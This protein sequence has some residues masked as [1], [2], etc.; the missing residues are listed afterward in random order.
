[1]IDARAIAIGCMRLS[2]EPDRE[3]ERSI[4]VLR[5]ALE[6]GVTLFD[7][8]DAYGLDEA[9][10]GH[11]ER[12][13]AR[14]LAGWPGDRSQ[15][16]IAT[17][18]GLTRA[19]GRWEPDGRAK[20]LAAACE[21]SCRAL[22]VRA[23]D[24]YQ[25]HAP[26]P[27]TSWSTSIRAL[28][29]LKRSGLVRAIG[30]CNV[31]VRDIEEARRIVDIDA[32]QIELSVWQDAGILGG[33]VGYCLKE[34]IPILAYRPLGGRKSRA[35][36]AAEPVLNDIAARH[37]VSPHEIAIA[38]VRDAAP[39]LI[40]PLPG[41]TRVE[42][43]RSAAHAQRLTLTSHDRQLLDE[44]F[45]AARML[46]AEHGGS[47][48]VS[49][50]RDGEVVMI[51]GIPAAGKTTLAERFERDGF[52]RLNRDNEGGTLR[53][54][55]SRLESAV[56]AGASRI[57][58]DN[59]YGSR[60]S[61][62]EVIRAAADRGLPVRCVWCTTSLEQ[63]QVNA[64]T[65]LI[66]RY[67][68]LPPEAEL[69]RLRKTDVSAFLPTVLFR[70][71]RQLEPPDASE[72]FSRIEQVPFA[73]ARDPAH[74]NRAVIVW[75]DDVAELESYAE[76]LRRYQDE[77]WPLLGLSWQ[78]SIASGHRTAVEVHETF[79]A[80]TLRLGLELQFDVCP[81]GAGPPR[82]WCRKPLPGL[83]VM[84]IQR[85]QLDPGQCL[86]LGKG[87]QDPAFARKLGFK[88]PSSA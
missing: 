66:R 71:Q 64:A 33:V 86:Y 83:G 19:G 55:I 61:R 47:R 56:D 3:D 22:D 11:N 18:G 49:S 84:L 26:D 67:R 32:I 45:P 13:I 50:R 37:G 77:A 76:V 82:C 51:M 38:W 48:S 70:H 12:L 40:A 69:E 15:L 46:R 29:G 62:A 63:A 28:A 57:V 60:K 73:P 44:R 27:R 31:T 23:I 1:M 78:P 52:H 53:D 34:R 4:A 16:S 35:R 88:L 65:R 75:C 30:L 21:R 10:V 74:V 59:T 8:A 42:T 5:A 72:G 9:D 87:P 36:T 39:E 81:H 41:V 68:T 17:K 25:L 7:T 54:L 85:H 79:A 20:Y 2:T 6:S 24:L 14:A 58:L 43:A 80:A